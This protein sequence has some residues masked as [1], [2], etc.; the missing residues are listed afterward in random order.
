[1]DRIVAAVAIAI[2]VLPSIVNGQH[3]TIRINGLVTSCVSTPVAN[4]A[5]SL[6]S[7]DGQFSTRVQ[8]NRE[9]RFEFAAVPPLN[10]KL[11][12]VTWFTKSVKDITSRDGADIHVGTIDLGI[13]PICDLGFPVRAAA[14]TSE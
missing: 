12:I 1:M 3:K 10:Y 11:L 13:D 2:A 9:G 4:A 7:V 5:V 6:T 8:T 14:G